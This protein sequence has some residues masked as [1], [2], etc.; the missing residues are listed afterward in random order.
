MEHSLPF[1]TVIM[2]IEH[3]GYEGGTVKLTDGD[4]CGGEALG[5]NEEG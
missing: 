1:D 2:I 3:K 4:R 5:S